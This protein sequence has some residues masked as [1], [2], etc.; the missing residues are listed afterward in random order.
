[1][2]LPLDKLRLEFPDFLEVG[3]VYHWPRVSGAEW[4]ETSSRFDNGPSWMIETGNG[5]FIKLWMEE[6]SQFNRENPF[7]KIFSVTLLNSEQDY[8]CHISGGSTDDM[9][10]VSEVITQV[11]W[12]LRKLP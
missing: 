8:I 5:M 2:S 11:H 1:M 9:H 12:A 7:T 4:I 3:K 10:T 6:D